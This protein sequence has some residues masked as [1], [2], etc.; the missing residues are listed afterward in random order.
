[1]ESLLILLQGLM[2]I[3]LIAVGVHYKGMAIGLFGAVGVLAFALLFQIA[4][5]SVPLS[6]ML[7]IM[8]VVTAAGAMHLAGG[9]DV[10][11]T[12]AQRATSW[13]AVVGLS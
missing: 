11:L 12:L 9:S 7:I 8:T 3:G 10:G 4:P 6:A 1:M 2:V 13:P 5:G